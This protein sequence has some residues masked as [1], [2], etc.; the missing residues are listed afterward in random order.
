MTRRFLTPIS[1][2]HVDFNTDTNSTTATGRALWNDGDGTLE[3]GLKGG[4]L[5]LKVGQEEVALCYNGTGSPLSKGTVV[6][7]SGS[8]GQRPALAKSNAS[9]ETTS[10]KTFGVVAENISNGAEGFVATFGIV[11]GLNTLA[12]TEGQPI[13]L[14]ASAG[15]MTSTMPQQ[16]NHSVFIGYCV[17]QHQSSGQI[18]VNIQNGYELQEL[19]NVL[20]TSPTDNQ[21]LTYDSSTGLWKNEDSAAA[22][23][24]QRD[25]NL[26][27]QPSW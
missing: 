15:L 27:W 21:V 19:H 11:R 25:W 9:T 1:T 5:N 12:L 26:Y 16:P 18:F 14:S 8:Q 4:N 2:N 3:V 24:S 20:I 6:Y 7:I 17:R 22:Q 23:A 10:S 13:W